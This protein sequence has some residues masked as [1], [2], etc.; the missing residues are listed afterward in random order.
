M[1]VSDTLNRKVSIPVLE[2]FSVILW[3]FQRESDIFI[4]FYSSSEC[5]FI[6]VLYIHM[7]IIPLEMLNSHFFPH[8]KVKSVIGMAKEN[9][10]V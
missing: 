7:E 2:K 6:S 4:R 10:C 5:E 9:G 1:S 8:S 3:Q